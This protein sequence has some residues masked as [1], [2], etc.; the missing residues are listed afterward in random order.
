MSARCKSWPAVMLSCMVGAACSEPAAVDDG[1]VE[2]SH[3]RISTTTDNPIC[4]GTPILLQRELER[5][6]A[7]VD[8]PLWDD[9]DKLDV[10]FGEDAV[11]D[12][13]ANIPLGDGVGIN[14]CVIRRDGE[15]VAS[16]VEV[17][18]TAPHEL[19]HAV[20]RHAQPLG[21][22]LFEEG[23]AELLSGS[24]GFP[25]QAQY[26]RGDPY[27]G[28]VELLEIPR[29]DF[30]YY[31]PGALSF[32]SWLWETE[33][34]STLMGFV[35]DPAVA[36][37]DA[38]LPLFEQHFGISLAEAEQAWRE[39]ERPDPIWGS[40]CIPEHTYS[41][42]D[43]PV[44][45]SGS[46]D[47]SEP[48]VYGASYWMSLPPMCLHVPE[49]TR[50]RIAFEADH[51]RLQVL[52]REPCDPGPSSAEADRSKTLHAGEVLEQDIVGCRF[53]MLVKSDA[54]GF[55]ATEYAIRIEEI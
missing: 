40:P 8:L 28:P 34:Q 31:Y 22:A 55:P 7:A 29:E 16:A 49:T 18:Y 37:A 26:P 25:V 35:N 11:A 10:R 17:S 20:R 1:V 51:G 33:G 47:C 44:E 5:I 21:P 32:V 52:L 39:D 53:R 3:L 50:V 6:A 46:F 24:E 48:E 13:C 38:T 9:G 23:L 12:A 54:A 36:D 15:L 30:A 41:L 14:G 45:V 2:T 19:V 43:G 27:V 42:A 4:A